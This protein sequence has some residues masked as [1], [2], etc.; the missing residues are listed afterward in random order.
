MIAPMHDC[1]TR[2]AATRP[3]NAKPLPAPAPER[4]AAQLRARSRQLRVRVSSNASEKCR[5]GLAE[6]HMRAVVHDDLA[7]N[8]RL[9]TD[10][11]AVLPADP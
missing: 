2:A 10:G 3:A 1:P 9:E 6:A 4:L 11:T 8:A 5:G 7:T